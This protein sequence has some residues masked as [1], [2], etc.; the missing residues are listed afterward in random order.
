VLRPHALTTLGR[1]NVVAALIRVNI[2]ALPWGSGHTAAPPC[3]GPYAA[4]EPREGQK[5]YGAAPP[6]PR[7]AGCHRAGYNLNREGCP[8]VADDPTPGP[9][10]GMPSLRH[11][12]QR[13]P[14][15]TPK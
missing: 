1:V 7:L 8:I 10:S 12:P 4:A 9:L 5:R 6:P 3:P 11:L 14:G 15:G 13:G 2:M